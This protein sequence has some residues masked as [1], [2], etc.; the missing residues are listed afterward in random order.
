MDD[1]MEMVKSLK[2]CGLLKKI[3]SETIENEA[4]KQQGRFLGILFG[5]LGT[6]LLENLSTG[7][8]V[9]QAVKGTIRADQGF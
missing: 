1:I 3:V 8:G 2:E 6:N 4:K 7:R 9:I 5:T